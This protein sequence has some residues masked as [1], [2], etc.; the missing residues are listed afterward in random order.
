MSWSEIYG[1][2]WPKDFF[3][4]VLRT[5]RVA[6]AYLFSGPPRVGKRTF[7]LELAKTLCCLTPHDGESCGQ[8]KSCRLFATQSHPDLVMLSP[9]SDTIKIDQVREFTRNLNLKKSI[10]EFKVG[11]LVGVERLTEEASNCLLKTVEEPPS[12]TVLILTTSRLYSVSSTILSRVQLLESVP[13]SGE[14]VKR[15]LVE[16]EH[17]KEEEAQHIAFL[18]TGS[19]GR[20]LE[21]WRGKENPLRKVL[22]FWK[23]LKEKRCITSFGPWFETMELHEMV[24]FLSL[25]ESYLRDVL[26]GMAMG[27]KNEELFFQREW[28]EDALEDAKILNPALVTRVIRLIEELVE[29]LSLYVQSDVA[30]IDFLGKVRGEMNHAMG[31]RNTI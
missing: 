2:H 22:D 31:S 3:Q 25:L 30:L 19:I 17:L 10:S 7:A 16:K 24:H 6:H 23:S 8:C 14:E 12:G 13:L 26:L 4:K 27:R 5:R 11:I 20:A 29:D 21:I 1:H 9:S 18:A 28:L 15:Y